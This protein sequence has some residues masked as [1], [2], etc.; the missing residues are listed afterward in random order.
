MSELKSY[1]K[2]LKEKQDYYGETICSFEFA[3]EEYANQFIEILRS[4]S[5]IRQILEPN[6]EN[7]KE[8]HFDE[9]KAINECLN[10]VDNAVKTVNSDFS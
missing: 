8:E 1:S 6:Y 5:R 3:A 9:L 10:S 4:V 2:I 7:V